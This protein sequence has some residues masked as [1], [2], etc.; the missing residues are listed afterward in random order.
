MN[1]AS[2]RGDNLKTMLVTV[3]FPPTMDI[4]ETW[5]RGCY[6]VQ[7]L[8]RRLQIFLRRQKIPVYLVTAGLEAHRASKKKKEKEKESTES[9]EGGEGS[10]AMVVKGNI[11]PEGDML[12]RRRTLAGHC[13]LHMT[14]LVRETGC[15]EISRAQMA[16][17]LQVAGYDVVLT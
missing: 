2:E 11:V 8:P 1:I 16:V 10:S 17:G 15:H 14:A 12:L 9:Q 4:P 5:S 3:N 13:H 6:L 7:R